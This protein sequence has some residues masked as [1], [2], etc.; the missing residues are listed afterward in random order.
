M[1]RG[2]GWWRGGDVGG[3]GMEKMINFCLEGERFGS[4]GGQDAIPKSGEKMM[5]GG[6][7]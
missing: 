3:V 7:R 6:G 2:R 5:E 4:N 1:E